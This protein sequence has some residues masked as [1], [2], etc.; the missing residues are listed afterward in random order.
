MA[1]CGALFC[2]DCA[3]RAV[4]TRTIWC[5]VPT[6]WTE[7]AFGRIFGRCA[8][9]RTFFTRHTA[10]RWTYGPSGTFRAFITTTSERRTVRSGVTLLLPA[11]LLYI[12]LVATAKC[13][14]WARS[15][16][17][18]PPAYCARTLSRRARAEHQLSGPNEKPYAEQQT[19]CGK[20]HSNHL[21]EFFI[22][23][24]IVVKCTQDEAEKHS[25]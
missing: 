18:A 10:I 14:R 4:F 5:E 16:V 21:F 3:C 11:A 12:A 24:I 17:A 25:E 6:R 22:L 23:I 20:N 8:S 13:P 9:I 2:T 1:T 7:N 19:E 15:A